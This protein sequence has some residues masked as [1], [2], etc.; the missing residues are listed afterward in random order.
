[1]CVCV[2]CVSPAHTRVH[3]I[4]ALSRLACTALHCPDSRVVRRGAA[5][6]GMARLCGVCVGCSP[7][8]LLS[9]QATGYLLGLYAHAAVGLGPPRSCC[10]GRRG[11]WGRLVCARR[12]RFKARLRS[13]CGSAKHLRHAPAADLE[14]GR[15]DPRCEVR[16][17]VVADFVV[18]VCVCACVYVFHFVSGGMIC[19][20]SVR[21]PVRVCLLL[22]IRQCSASVCV[23]VGL[24][25][26]VCKC[27]VSDFAVVVCR[28][29]R[30]TERVVRPPQS[31]RKVMPVNN[32]YPN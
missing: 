14:D 7:A 16:R 4:A 26:L 1:M 18:G 21:R 12:Q 3:S 30:E 6:R 8:C 24:V 15:R 22:S 31:G 9:C 10:A 11:N 32:K 2:C 28:I 5:C 27:S 19:C 17:A 25:L 20:W 13:L 29:A 23:S